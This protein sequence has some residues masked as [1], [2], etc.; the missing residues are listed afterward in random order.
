MTKPLSEYSARDLQQFSEVIGKAA[1]ERK[2][3]AE[4]FDALLKSKRLAMVHQITA[5]NY[6]AEAHVLE[7]AAQLLETLAAGKSKA[8]A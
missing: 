2:Q 5:I 6:Q 3:T 8:A 4:T 1:S 7:E